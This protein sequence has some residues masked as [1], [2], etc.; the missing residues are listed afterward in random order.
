MDCVLVDTKELFLL[1]ISVDVLMVFWLF[2]KMSLIFKDVYYSAEI[3]MTSYLGFVS[4]YFRE[5]KNKQKIIR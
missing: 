3:K 5:G 1:L 2:K 4:N